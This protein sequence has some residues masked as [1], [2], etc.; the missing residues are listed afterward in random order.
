M[1]EAMW[2]P[3]AAPVASARDAR[4]DAARG[5]A[6]VL[7]VLGHALIGV[8]AAGTADTRALRF[9]VILIYTSHVALF[10]LISGLLAGARPRQPWPGLL[11]HLG[12]RLGWPYLLWGFVLYTAHYLM[13]DATNTPL[14]TYA[15]WRILWHPPGVMWFLPVLGLGLILHRG[16]WRWGRW[17][18][19][20]GGVLVLLAPYGITSLPQ[21][22]RFAG[23][24]PL[25][26]A[27]G[28][29]MAT[30]ACVM[31]GMVAG[32]GLV[33]AAT[34]GLVWA[35][36]AEPLRGYPAFAP[37]YLPALLAGPLLLT[38]AV[39]D[40]A[41]LAWIGRHTMPIFVTHVL[42]TA[43]VRIALT[44]AGV[45]AP[46][47]VVLLGTGLGVALPLIAARWAA[48]R[49]LEGVLGWR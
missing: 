43:G 27:L 44:Q 34:A 45:T 31:P 2:A 24:V 28:P 25:A 46:A 37:V 18:L 16:L 20:L 39:G 22:L 49:G 5:A 7:V 33:M 17:V 6:M 21:E 4:L 3:G 19:V 35:E 10:F 12:G 29:G 40:T 38:W 15:P 42:I 32:A 26:A 1:A 41:L 30:R 11:R 36:A 47:L 48:D 14:T 23:L 9:V 8:M 13:G